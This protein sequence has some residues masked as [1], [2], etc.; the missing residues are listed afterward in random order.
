MPD[1]SKGR[2]QTKYSPWSTRFGGGCGANDPT[3]EKLTV[4]KPPEIMEKGY[5]VGHDPYRVVAPVKENSIRI[6]VQIMK[7]LIIKGLYLPVSSSLLV[8]YST[9]CGPKYALLLYD[10]KNK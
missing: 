7:L 5:R 3:P 10:E 9:L 8:P 6:R 1:R 4:T 2:G